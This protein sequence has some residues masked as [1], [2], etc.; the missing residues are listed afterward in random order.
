MRKDAELIS[1]ILGV[2][3]C[4]AEL[5]DLFVGMIVFKEI[6]LNLFDF[7]LSLINDEILSDPLEGKVEVNYNFDKETTQI[8]IKMI[9]DR[10]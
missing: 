4:G 7:K 8:K 1:I 2:A 6:K 3:C 5:H 10:Y 9:G